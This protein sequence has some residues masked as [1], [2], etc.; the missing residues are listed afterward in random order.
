MIELIRACL[1]SNIIVL[2]V[3]LGLIIFMGVWHFKRENTHKQEK[4]ELKQQNDYHCNE[5]KKRYGEETDS[6]GYELGERG[7]K[8]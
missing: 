7:N 1:I 3:L 6:N 4:A 2:L 5:L 8:R